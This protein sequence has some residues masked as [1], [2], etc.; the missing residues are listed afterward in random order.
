MGYVETEAPVDTLADTCRGGGRDCWG[1]TEEVKANAFVH[2][3]A[4]TIR[5]LMTKTSSDT[6]RDEEAQTLVDMLAERQAEMEAK[7]V[8]NPL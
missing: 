5:Q 8:G 2:R 1:D 7:A 4:D 3:K 6:L